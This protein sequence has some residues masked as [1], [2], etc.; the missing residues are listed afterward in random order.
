MRAQLIGNGLLVA[1]LPP[2]RAA[3]LAALQLQ[4]A[5]AEALLCLNDAGWREVLSF[6]DRSQLTLPLA[7]RSC[8]GFPSWVNERLRRNL[9]DTARRFEHT[10]ETYCEIAAALSAARVPHMVL[11]GF[12]QTPDFVGAPQYRTQSDIDLFTDQEHVHP[13]I[14]ALL[15]IGYESSEL[16]EVY[17]YADH[18]PTLSRFG[19]WRPGLNP[20]DPEMPLAI[21]VHYCLWNEAVS[22]IALPEMDG[23][24]KRR[25]ERRL[26]AFSFPALSPVD[27]LG[28]FALH[29][30]RELF[31]GSRVLHHVRELA[32]CLHRRAD[33][34]AFWAEWQSL[35][36][37]RLRQMQAVPLALAG[38]AFSSRVP[39]AVHEQIES[40]PAA[41][42]AWMERCG[43]DLLA[44]TYRRTRS[45]RLLQLLLSDSASVRRTVLW[46]AV[47]PREIASPAEVARGIEPGRPPKRNNR[48]QPTR[49]PAYLVSR[50]SY[51]GIAVFRFLANGL[52]IL[53]A[54]FVGRDA[55][56]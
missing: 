47:S 8:Q 26:G 21:D 14:E 29:V 6:C 38:A 23:F 13:A 42:R 43:G 50:I 20:F 15:G 46:R 32:N 9:A 52:T 28:Y 5:G 16:A 40:L 41:L 34:A 24:W 51:N 17:R 35:H 10:Q 12:A 2:R 54:N 4:G 44:Q 39:E 48:W 36:S 37:L 7:L 1:R 45:G 33:D 53:L 56:S 49:Y 30:L 11:K 22:L 3:L 18:V 55:A 27:H 31:A 19:K 25:V